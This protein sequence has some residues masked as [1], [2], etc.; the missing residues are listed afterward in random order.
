MLICF[1]KGT[2]SGSAAVAGGTSN[3]GSFESIHLAFYQTNWS[4]KRRLGRNYHPRFFQCLIVAQISVVF[5]GL[6]L[7]SSSLTGK[8]PA[9]LLG[10]SHHNNIYFMGQRTNV[11]MVPVL[12]YDYSTYAIRN[13]GN[14][15]WKP[16]DH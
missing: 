16:T 3:S 1:S 4:I 13:M 12:K 14:N 6:L 11:W 8:I 2:T 15:H 9:V 7:S 10:S 5:P